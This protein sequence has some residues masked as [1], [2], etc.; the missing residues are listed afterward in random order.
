MQLLQMRILIFLTIIFLTAC[1]KSQEVP[2]KS[3]EDFHFPYKEL[4]EQKSFVYQKM[5]GNEQAIIT[6]RIIEQEGTKY[7]TYIAGSGTI[8][9]DSSII[10]MDEPPLLIEI[11]RYEYDTLGVFQGLTKGSIKKE[12]YF[13]NGTAYGGRE[14]RI[15]Y[16]FNN[17]ETEYQTLDNFKTDTFYTWN[18]IEIPALYFERTLKFK[19][20]HRFIPFV[21]KSAEYSGYTIYAQKLGIVKYANEMDGVLMEWELVQIK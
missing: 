20:S 13:S 11:Y 3:M 12:E 1:T 7:F 4:G 16:E 21:G 2:I 14:S 19:A 10:S 17:I 9:F 15:K 6:Q 5:G 18:N 8:K